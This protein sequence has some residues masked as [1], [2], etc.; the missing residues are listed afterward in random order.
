MITGSMRYLVNV[1]TLTTDL[2]NVPHRDMR[3]SIHYLVSAHAL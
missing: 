2:V 3:G 1:K